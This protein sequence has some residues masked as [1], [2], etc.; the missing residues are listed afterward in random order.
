MDFDPALCVCV[1]VC[2]GVVTSAEGLEP[3]TMNI[4]QQII[5]LGSESHEASMVA[6][7][8]GTV[9]V[10]EQVNNCHALLVSHHSL[11]NP[12][13]AMLLLVYK[14]NCLCHKSVSYPLC[15]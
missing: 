9:T 1:C 11:S 15:T 3:S 10:V 14:I 7:A 13:L 12:T 4:L 8:P 6:M 2:V 5:E